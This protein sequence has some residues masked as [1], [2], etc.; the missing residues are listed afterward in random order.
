MALLLLHHQRAQLALEGVERS[1]RWVA[2][3]RHVHPLVAFDRAGAVGHH[4]DAVGQV[5]RLFNRV[6]DKQDGLAQFLPDAQQLVLQIAPGQRVQRA[7]RFVHQHDRR[8]QRQ[9]AGNRHP[10]AHA[11]GEVFR[12]AVAKVFQVQQIQQLIHRLGDV[13]ARFL[14]HLQAKGDVLRHGHPRK[15]RVLLKHHAAIRAGAEDFFALDGDFARR[16]RL[17][18]GHGVQQGGFAAAGRPQQA[19]KLAGLD[20]QLNVFQRHHRATRRGEHFLHIIDQNLAHLSAP[21]RDA[22]AADGCSGG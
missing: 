3:A 9:H 4:H 22:S 21:G 12:V 18:T 11:A 5:D 17:K 19:D 15:Q 1:R 13:A 8:I 16:R 2:W 10:L 7:K 6:G 20:G 14:L